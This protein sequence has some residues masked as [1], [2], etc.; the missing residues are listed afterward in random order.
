MQGWVTE[1]QGEA[2]IDLC[3]TIACCNAQVA[4]VGLGILK[5]EGLVA[6]MTVRRGGLGPASTDQVVQLLD[7]GR[8]LFRFSPLSQRHG[9]PSELLGGPLLYGLVHALWT[10]VWWRGP[11][12]CAVVGLS[13]LCGGDGLAGILGPRLGH[14][15]GR[16]PHNRD[17]V[18]T[19]HHTNVPSAEL[20]DVTFRAEGC[21]E[22]FRSLQVF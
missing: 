14:M 8:N 10:L 2:L 20:C 22:Y 6:G 11:S 17:K 4:L 7:T 21:M 3:A 9:R 19:S 13:A 12:P 15:L 5:D 18:R 1:Q 16:L